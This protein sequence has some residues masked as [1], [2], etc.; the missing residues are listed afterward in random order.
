MTSAIDFGSPIT[1]LEISRPTSTITVTSGRQ[2]SFI[3]INQNAGPNVRLNLAYSPSCASLH[4]DRF[5]TGRTDDPW[6]R[7]H[8]LDGTEKEILK[9]HHGPVHCLEFSPDGEMFAS[10]SGKCFESVDAH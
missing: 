6:V 1:S 4:R 8:A 9:G 10:G 7:V 3:P 5:V 2:V